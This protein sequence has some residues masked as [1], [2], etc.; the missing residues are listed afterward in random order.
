MSDIAHHDVSI[1]DSL[2]RQTPEQRCS[3][4]TDLLDKDPELQPVIA[5]MLGLAAMTL[6]N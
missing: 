1:L 5:N 6:S 4:L 2:L 3:Q